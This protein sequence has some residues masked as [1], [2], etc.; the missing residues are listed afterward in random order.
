MGSTPLS[1][2][3]YLR[4]TTRFESNNNQQSELIMDITKQQK[5]ERAD[6]IPNHMQLQKFKVTAFSLLVQG[7]VCKLA[8][9]WY[10]VKYNFSYCVFI[11]YCDFN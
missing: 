2:E 6:F 9:I 1:P 3:I 11:W 7:E 10:F 4:I 5:S 8:A